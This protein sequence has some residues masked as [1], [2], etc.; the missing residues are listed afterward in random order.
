MYIDIVP[1]RSSPPAILLRESY[2]EGGK[3][4]K[5]TVVNLSKVLTVEQAEVMKLVLK[6]VPLVPADV[7]EVTAS[8]SHGAVSAVLLAMKRLDL[9]GLLGARSCRE[10][11][12]VLLMI[13]M[14]ILKPGTKLAMT[15]MWD[16]TTLLDELGL[17]ADTDE[18]DLYAAMDW[19]IARKDGIE[20]KLAGR[21]LGNGD[22][23]LFDMTS[24]YVEGSCSQL[25]EFGYSRDKKRGKAQINWGLLTD[26][27][28]RPVALEV[29]PGN[30]RDSATLL[31]QVQKL[32]ERF[33][34]DN[35]TIV[36]D[37][38]MVTG[39]HIESLQ[40]EAGVDW[41]TALASG[42]IRP[43]VRSGVIQQSLFEETN[44]F[45]LEHADYPGERLVACRNPVLGRKRAHVRTELITA[46]VTELEKVQKL[47]VNGKLKDAG[48]I[49]VRVGRVVNNRKM[50]KH[51][52]LTIDTGVFEFEVNQDSVNE[53]AALDGIYVIRTSVSRESMTAAETVIAYKNLT[54]VER[55]FRTSKSLE[56][57]VRPIHHWLDDRVKA[58]LFICMLAYYVR[59]H[60]QE[61]W[62]SITFQDEAKPDRQ[63]LDPV[64]PAERSEAARQKASSRIL[65]DGSP[66]HSFKTLLEDLAS[67]TRNTCTYP[68]AKAPFE[69][70]TSPN[71]QQQKALN[72]IKNIRL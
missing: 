40:G 17:P 66:V 41:I 15:R 69:V 49:G 19:L 42:S 72:L 9:G 52:N 59:W 37:R 56:L 57:Q 27:A 44:L 62:T 38:G 61:A 16:N 1:N 12:L 36:G 28:G 47:V 23:A 67:I 24:S 54:N 64:A 43:L 45:E 70:T 10:R 34:L 46:T 32:K 68:Q 31:P 25:A 8:R 60:M 33:Q 58:H 53:E 18:N 71:P 21:H 4:K 65:P 29:L 20:Q 48:R 51:F 30:V 5:R 22:M 11:S 55:A 7:F 63:E 3:V 2:R 26:S 39:K 35:F 13:A 14:R 6:D 50:Q